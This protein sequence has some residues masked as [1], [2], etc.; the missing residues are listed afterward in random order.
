M[1]WILPGLILTFGLAAFSLAKLPDFSGVRGA[2]SLLPLWMILGIAMGAVIVMIMTFQ[3]MASGVQ[4][5]LAALRQYVIQNRKR[6]I[7]LVPGMFLAG[8]NM[9]VFM[10]VKQLL[11]YLVP[12]WADPYLAAVDHLIFFADPWR[13]L[14]PLDT[15][16]F[17]LFYHRGWFALI[18][19]ALLRVLWSAP[20]DEKT[21]LMLTYFLLWSIFGPIVHTLLP[22]AGPVFYAHLG[23]GDRFA[24]LGMTAETQKLADYVWGVY[25]GG[26]FGPAAGISAMPS[27]HIATSAW[28]VIAMHRFARR[29]LAVVAALSTLI[30]VLSVALGWHYGVDGIVGAAGAYFIWR[31]CLRISRARTGSVQTFAG[32]A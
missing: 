1:H 31:G 30:F 14:T 6:L 15:F 20:S 12:F 25:K 18:I 7:L 10:W 9:V 32:A 13:F 28:A 26:V 19:I 23:Y 11:N 16:G 22:A 27:L 2:L 21:A 3:M 5:P 17:A 29:W 8:L 24:S 4:R